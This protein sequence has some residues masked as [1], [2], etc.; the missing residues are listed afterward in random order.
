M[1][2]PFERVATPYQIFSWLAPSMEHSIDAI[3]AED[4]GLEMSEMQ[5][6]LFG[7]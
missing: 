7:I 2:H 1:K 5:E 6:I 3:R 4:G